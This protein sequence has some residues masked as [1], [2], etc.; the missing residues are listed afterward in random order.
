MKYIDEDKSNILQIYETIMT[1]YREFQRT[2]SFTSDI[3]RRWYLIEKV[4]A[5]YVHHL[6]WQPK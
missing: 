3:I 1:E 2:S 4:I 5:L 6:V